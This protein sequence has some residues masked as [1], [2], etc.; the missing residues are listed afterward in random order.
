[1]D[2][3]PNTGLFDL[4]GRITLLTGSRRGLGFA[5]ARGMGQ[6]GARI[7]LNARDG[8]LL[9]EAVETLRGEGLDVFRCAFDVTDE[10]AVDAGVKQIEAEVGPIDVL[11]N[12]AGI[13]RRGE[14]ASLSESDWREVLATNL[15]GPFLIAQRVA[16]GMIDRREGKIINICSV[17]SELGRRTTGNYAASKGGLKMLTRAMAVEWAEHNVQVNAIGPGYFL[18]DMTRPLAEDAKF[19]AWL[20]ARTPAR[21]WGKPEELIGAAVFL[22]SRASDFVNGQVL[23]VDGGILAAL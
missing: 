22:A 18:T 17:M 1:M 2:G 3:S 9:D 14:L 8:A 5:L 12:N 11:V 7:V 10:Q 21:R 15:T 20:K 16:Q 6:A 19:D 4:H 13:Q 23:Y